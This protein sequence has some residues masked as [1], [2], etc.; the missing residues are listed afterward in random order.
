MA[1]KTSFVRIGAACALLLAS[2]FAQARTPAQPEQT[3]IEMASMPF[4][5]SSLGMRFNLPL[6]ATATTR[7][8]GTEVQADIVGPDAAYRISITSRSSAN[9]E[10]TSAAA[11]ESILLNL[12]KAFGVSDGDG[13]PDVTI[14]TFAQE[15]RTVEPVPFSEG[16]AHRFFIRQPETRQEGDSVRGVAVIDLGRGRMLVWDA[17]APAGSFDKLA[18]AFDAMLGT[19]RFDDPERRLADRGIAIEAGR[20]LIDSIDPEQLRAAFDSDR[21]RWFRLYEPGADQDR[22]IGYR[23]VT[24]WVGTRDEIELSAGSSGDATQGYLV[25]IEARTL[26]DISQ[27]TGEPII[28]DS[29]GTYW[30][31]EDFNAETWELSVA[32]REGSRTTTLSEIGAREGQEELIVTAQ[33][34]SGRSETTSHRLEGEGYLAQ[35]LAL[36]LPQLL[37]GTETAGDFAFYVYRSDTSAIAYRTDSL[38]RDDN[39]EGWILRS[40]VAPGTPELVKFLEADGSIRREQL[41]DGK[42][43]DP[44]DSRELVNLWRRKGLPMK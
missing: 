1:S 34:P 21:D 44:I 5:L 31:S 18:P 2:P 14:A 10:L 33:A 30:V 11:A 6:G 42:V 26:G 12:K 35:P 22:E 38:R 24:T 37:V 23:R 29:R 27:L 40:R 36:L 25:R 15:L 43:W 19:V 39:G 9:T 8:I 16:V 3:P 20:R 28:Y 4:E 13:N 32:I 7:R 41:P 17:T